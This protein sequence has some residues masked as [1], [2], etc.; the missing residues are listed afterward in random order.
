MA[1]QAFLGVLLITLVVLV[2]NAIAAR[3]IFGP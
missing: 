3:I 1:V 2:I